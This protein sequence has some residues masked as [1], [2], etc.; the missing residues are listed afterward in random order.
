MKIND[1]QWLVKR[2]IISKRNIFFIISLTIICIILFLCINLIDYNFGLKSDSQKKSSLYRTLIVYGNKEKY[3][4]L[5]NINHVLYVESTKYYDGML[6]FPNE[7]NQSD[8]KGE[9]ELKTYFSDLNIEIVN[10]EKIQNSL[11]AI[12]PD[13]FYPH[14]TYINKTTEKIYPSYFLKNQD[15]IGRSFTVKS[16]NEDFLDKEYTFKIVG[17]YNAKKIQNSVNSCYIL[18]EDIDKIKSNYKGYG[19]ITHADGTM[20][21]IYDEY[22]DVFIRVDDYRNTED[23]ANQITNMGFS[24]QVATVDDDPQINAMISQSILVCIILILICVNIIYNFINKKVKYN[25]KYYSLL[26]CCGYT[27]AQT[28][29]IEILENIELSLISILL[30]IMIYYIIYYVL[31]NYVLVQVIYN[32]FIIKIPLIGLSIMITFILGLTIMFSISLMKKNLKNFINN[33]LGEKQ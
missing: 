11:E 19:T 10:G 7:F 30:A 16:K 29:K 2:K 21:E 22:D 4:E 31:I 26:K 15:I 27:N 5:K 23:V 18:K 20:E 9:L 1:I 32:N 24:V 25:G 12:C 13:S 6:V 14:S 17:T 28:Y 3:D 8:L 33:L